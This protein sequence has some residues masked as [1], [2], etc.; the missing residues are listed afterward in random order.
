[1]NSPEAQ[2][3]MANM[4][5]NPAVIDQVR[6]FTGR[7]RSILWS[8][9]TISTSQQLIASNPELQRMGPQV[10]EISALILT[11]TPT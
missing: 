8:N 3:N 11:P 2:A 6:S 9:L 7:F 1:M 10:R 5:N 4:L